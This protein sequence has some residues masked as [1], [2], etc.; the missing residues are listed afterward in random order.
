MDSES[1]LLV[2]FCL[3]KK[4]KHSHNIFYKEELRRKILKIYA[5]YTIV[6]DEKN[7]IFSSSSSS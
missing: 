1:I 5:L 6:I 4:F 7:V 3:I 2:I